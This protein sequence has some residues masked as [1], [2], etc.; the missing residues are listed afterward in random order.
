MLRPSSQATKEKQEAERQSREGNSGRHQQERQQ[1]KPK[2]VW[3]KPTDK[4]VPLIA[5][6]TEQA[7]RDFVEKHQN[8]ANRIFVACIKRWPITSLHPFGTLVEQ[9]GEM[10]DLKV[11]TDA[12]LRDNNFG[13]DDFSDAVLKSV[14]FDDWSVQNEGEAALAARRDFRDEKTFTID[15]NGTKELDDA[16]HLKSLGDGKVEIG[17]HVA[18][19]AHFIKSNSLVDREAKKRGTGV[20]LM[21]RAV[22]MLPPKLS[23]E[24]CSLSPG[25]ERFTVSVV[26]QVDPKTGLVAEDETWI[27][28]AIIKSSGKLSYDDVDAVI[29]GDENIQLQGPTVNDI[30]TLFVSQTLSPGPKLLTDT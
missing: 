17:I 24:I 30:K 13:P 28:K 3:F 18:D 15:P 9:L 1:D 26:F 27:G 6:P 8:Y 2:I 21:N 14:G 4:R 22:N 23:S 25:E 29:H 20:Y 12:L 16:M 5:I 11:E 7:P 19:V 10:G